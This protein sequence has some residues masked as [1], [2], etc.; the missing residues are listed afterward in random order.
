MHIYSIIL[1]L[2]KVY[3]GIY[4]IRINSLTSNGRFTE[5]KLFGVQ[6]YR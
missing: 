1:H 6:R 4:V 2:K 3:Y 5:I